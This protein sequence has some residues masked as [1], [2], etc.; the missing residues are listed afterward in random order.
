[1]PRSRNVILKLPPIVTLNH[2][3]S[4]YHCDAVRE[5]FHHIE[6]KYEILQ[7]QCCLHETSDGNIIY[8]AAVIPNDECLVS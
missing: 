6:T 8:F 4:L 3:K 5:N 2:I 1:M 7:L